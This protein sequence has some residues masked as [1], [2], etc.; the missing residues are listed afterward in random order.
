MTCKRKGSSTLGKGFILTFCQSSFKVIMSVA[1][2][3]IATGRYYSA[4]DF[5]VF[6]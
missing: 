4:V 6:N 2:D 1:M 3:C 5:D